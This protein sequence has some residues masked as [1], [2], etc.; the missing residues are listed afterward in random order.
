M[1]KLVLLILCSVVCCLAFSSCG[2]GGEGSRKKYALSVNDFMAGRKFL[3]FSAP[4]CAF[5]I[6]PATFNSDEIVHDY[7]LCPGE[8]YVYSESN[9]T[10]VK[11]VYSIP[12]L[13]YAVDQDGNAVLN[14]SAVQ[15]SNINSYWTAL[16]G[17]LA[18]TG[19]E[20]G[21]G[22]ADADYV[23]L[24]D[25]RITMNFAGDDKGVWEDSCLANYAG[26]VALRS[27]SGSLLLRPYE[28]LFSK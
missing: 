27:G 11:A 22:A 10:T 20:L 1:K 25:V 8:I 4:S 28:F 17:A 9:S 24:S 16:C 13:R 12:E 5:L 3:L 23:K 26:G 19:G 6:K 18:G 15:P 14:F 21:G 7:V 2:G